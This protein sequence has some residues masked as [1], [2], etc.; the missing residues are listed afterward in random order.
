MS[1][2]QCGEILYFVIWRV[3]PNINITRKQRNLLLY[4]D[5]VKEYKWLHK[6]LLK[7][8]TLKEENVPEK[9]KNDFTYVAPVI[10]KQC[11]QEWKDDENVVNPVEDLGQIERQKC[12]L[13]GTP[14]R[15]LCYIQNKINGKRINIGRDC[16]QEEAGYSISKSFFNA[17]MEITGKRSQEVMKSVYLLG[18]E[19]LK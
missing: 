17:W 8:E 15:Y 6:L 5:I 4:S 14:T 18:K 3:N 9:F 10:L 13:C 7:N 1:S 11:G 16:A 19:L 2:I 12:S